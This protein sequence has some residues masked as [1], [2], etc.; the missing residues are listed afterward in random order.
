MRKI[1]IV[2]A[3]SGLGQRIAM[4]FARAGW[5]VGIAARREAPLQAIKDVYPHNVAYS[6]IDVTKEDAPAK[7]LDLIETTGGM[8]I[9]LF[10]A[11]VGFL[12]PELEDSRLDNT[13][14]T[15]V[16]GFARIIAA[17]YKYYR[18]TPRFNPGQIAAITSVAG[19]RGI[20][21]S[22]AYSS[23]KR[24]QQMFLDSLDQLS[25]QQHVNVRITDIRPGFIRTPL[26]KEG[27]P[28]PLL[29]SVDHAAPLIERA[30]LRRKRVAVI[31]SRWAVVTGL[32]KLVPQCVW[33]RIAI[34]F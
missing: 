17:A 12:D 4:D 19:T 10:A 24:F 32:W 1:V 21:V 3:S 18:G 28:Y 33:K 2:G 20:G 11:G 31:D 16:V 25:R 15:N 13:L 5:R 34:N 27:K 30:I 23:S 6:V 8:D 9:L 29:M 26:L 14:Q 22:A 7:F